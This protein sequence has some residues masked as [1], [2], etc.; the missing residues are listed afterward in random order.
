M[1][2]TDNPDVLVNKITGVV[3]A[4]A[5]IPTLPYFETGLPLFVGAVTFIICRA[6]LFLG[7]AFIAI[8][9]GIKKK[10]DR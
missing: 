5:I 6:V 10:R 1:A 8:L 3:I 9:T 4:L 7:M 2:D